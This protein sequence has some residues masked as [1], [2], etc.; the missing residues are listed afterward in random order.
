MAENDS[1]A[2][3][4]LDDVVIA[5]EA[6]CRESEIA[7]HEA[8][9]L[10]AESQK[11]RPLHEAFGAGPGPTLVVR[12]SQLQQRLTDAASRLRRAQARHLHREGLSTERIAELF[13]VTRQRISALL[14]LPEQH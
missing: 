1:E 13:G 12:L 4:A 5:L 7:A 14:R 11:G 2:V 3:D 6:T 9:I 8:K 10:R